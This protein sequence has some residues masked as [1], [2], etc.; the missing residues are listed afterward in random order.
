MRRSRGNET[1]TFRLAACCGA[2]LLSIFAAPAFGHPMKVTRGTVVVADGTLTLSLET[3][4]EALLHAEKLSPSAEGR[5]AV[6]AIRRAAESYGQDMRRRIAIRDARG[7]EVDGRL[8][9]CSLDHD[10]GSGLSLDDLRQTLVRCTLKFALGRANEYLSFQ[11]VERGVDAILP[12]TFV[13]SVR[14][15]DVTLGTVRLTRGGN[16]EIVR[17]TS[18]EGSVV[19]QSGCPT[20]RFVQTDSQGTIRA[21][22]RIHDAGVRLEVFMTV[23]MLETWIA[24]KRSQRDFLEV[25]EQIRCRAEIARFM[26]KYNRMSIDGRRVEA[27]RIDIEFLD[28]GELGGDAGRS[29]RRLSAWTSRVRITMEYDSPSHPGSVDL[30]WTL[31]NA[32]VL[33]AHALIVVDGNCLERDLSTYDPH[34]GWTAD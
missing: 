11:Q 14:A 17:L 27:R 30:Y 6:E 20:G 13:L 19:E 25:D 28:V 18:K 22:L 34:L 23:R 10:G 24:L 26:A 3:P 5:Y 1:A 16:V 31:F 29:H 2:W 9:S 8:E 15:G 7:E 33:T 12:S 21:I 4:A 32:S